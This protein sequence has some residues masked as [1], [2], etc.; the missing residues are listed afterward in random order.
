MFS[1]DQNPGTFRQ[2]HLSM[3]YKNHYYAMRYFLSYQID[4]VYVIPT[5]Y[6]AF[7]INQFC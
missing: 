3:N 4:F 2:G 7:K 6:Q 1:E 5:N